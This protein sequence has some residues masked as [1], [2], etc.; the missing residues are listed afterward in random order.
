M[1]RIFWL[2]TLLI[3]ASLLLSSCLGDDDNS[4]TS[5]SDMAITGFTLG[6]LNRYQHLTSSKT[7]N[8]TVVKS[9]LSGSLYAMTIDHLGKRIYN[10]KALPEGTDVGH[11]LCTLTTKNNGVVYLMSTT[12][13]SL[14]LHQST[15]SVDLTTPRVFR[16]FAV[17]GSGS[18]DYTVS[19]NV[20]S[21][22]GT[23]FSWMKKGSAEPTDNFA[24]KHLVALADSVWLVDRGIVVKGDSAFRMSTDGLAERSA[25]LLTWTPCDGEKQDGLSLIGA[26]SHELFALATD[27]SLMRSADGGCTWTQEPLDEDA[28]LLPKENI[29]IVSWPYQTAARTDYVLMVGN[30]P[31]PGSQAVSIWRKISPWGGNA[32]WTYMNQDDRNHIRLPQRAQLSMAVFDNTVLA[33]GQN[34]IVYQTRDQGITWR[35]ST[36]LAL[37]EA[38]EGDAVS[39][40]AD[41]QGRV[42]VVTDKGQV[43]QGA[44]R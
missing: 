31:L 24:D 26:S 42:W 39:M 37:P 22:T 36:T 43:W 7:G 40:T 14:R 41:Q 4:S 16:V 20:D 19:L 12:S 10:E 27:G 3:T 34:K 17:D 5:Y 9:T 1:K 6:T 15:D 25:D 8:D 35:Q 18:R 21:N 32:F 11:V 28:S 23:T 29:D 44:M 30:D 13:D 38:L 2:P 33:I